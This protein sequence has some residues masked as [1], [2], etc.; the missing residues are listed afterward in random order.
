MPFT[1]RNSLC[2]EACVWLFGKGHCCGLVFPSATQIRAH[3]LMDVTR[4]R[5]SWTGPSLHSSALQKEE[6]VFFFLPSLL[7]TLYIWKEALSVD[8]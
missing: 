4:L 6:K 7:T 2:L 8:L 3:N 5:D 1:L